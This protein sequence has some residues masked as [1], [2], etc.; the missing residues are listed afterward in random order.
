MA[1]SSRRRNYMLVS[2]RRDQFI[3]YIKGLLHHS[4]VLDALRE[5]GTN[6]WKHVEELIE[7]HRMCNDGSSRLA[8]AVPTI[9]QF[10]TPLPLA[11]T[12][13]AFD[14]RHC[15]SKR[16]FVQ[17]SF[18]EIR[19][20]LN[21]AQV[22]A[23]EMKTSEGSNRSSLEFVS[24]DGDCTLYSD[25]KNFNDPVLAHQILRLL[26]AGV[27]VA[28]V[29]AA[30]YGYDAA[31]YERRLD[32]LLRVLGVADASPQTLRRFFVVGGES[33]YL[34]QLDKRPGSHHNGTVSLVPRS[35]VWD[36]LAIVH[37]PDSDVETLLDVAEASIRQAI[38]DFNLDGARVIRKPRA[39]GLVP[40]TAR[41][42]Q[43]DETVLRVQNALR[44][45]PTNIPYCAF[46]GGNDVWV[47]VGNK[48]VGVS[49]LQQLFDLKP[50]N[51]LHIG[52]QFLNTGND[53]AARGCAP[54]ILRFILD[55]VNPDAPPI[56]D[57][58]WMPP[59]PTRPPPVPGDLTE[60]SLA[61]GACSV[62]ALVLMGVMMFVEVVTFA[63]RSPIVTK[64]DVDLHS[65]TQLRI[66]F[67]LSFPH[68]HCDF[69]SIDVWDKIGRNQ[70]NLSR[71]I[72]KWQLDEDGTRRMY[73]GRNR[74][75]Y[76]I[77]HDL[78]HPPLHELHADGV[79]VETVG[80]S[81]WAH[82]SEENEFSFV[83]FYAP[84]CSFC[85][86]LHSTWE[87]LAEE[88]ERRELPVA[89][90]S[91]DCVANGD[92][93]H[94]MYVQAFPTL[95]F[96]HHGDQVN[97][98]EYRFD[99]TVESLLEFVN[100]KLDSEAVYKQYPEARIAH[101]QNWNADHPGCLVSGYV[102]VN[103]VPGNFHIQAHS[104]HHSLNTF[105]TNLSH[106]V[107]HLSFGV[108]LN[109][110]QKRRLDGLD[111]K[112]HLTNPIDSREY[113]HG[114]FHHAYHHY[115]HVVPT[116]YRI[117][118]FWREKFHTYQMVH[119]DHLAFYEY[120]EPPEARFAFDLSPM[121]V[122]VDRVQK[123]WY[124]F[125]TGLLAILGGTFAVARLLNDAFSL[126]SRG[127]S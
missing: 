39:I 122:V 77:E 95:R 15:V 50:P 72:E 28:L 98:G 126:V 91:V 14:S 120:W 83:N 74:R 80:A 57:N 16:V 48:K 3:E 19:W 42:E 79:H 92:F 123:K 73:Q 18:N 33:N 47:D 21:E 113:L 88:I 82:F 111:I 85:Q 81:D 90:A 35:D 23:F 30:G 96:Y 55:V 52:D 53:Y 124:D 70:L 119:A 86:H 118:T 69:A 109:D 51:C 6:S 1:F 60:A 37:F 49:G 64:I 89:V 110:W 46:N 9:G 61:G 105:R 116:K 108:P 29:T 94:D 75:D 8:Q 41:R 54:Q 26:E 43:L 36:E 114:D 4:F 40:T 66:N 22:R 101:K 44:D 2:H 104:R 24:F 27:R 59:S 62:V 5:T 32:G 78:H 84:W 12:W 13:Q 106:T 76:D 97:Q 63:S 100:K 58:P 125:I 117:G 93:C 65:G 25:G 115:I 87:A 11:A 38:F 67:N 127:S 99:R 20:I 10:F 34:L 112:Y 31:R 103:R 7:E 68:L 121:A 71:N 17:P 107:H 102:M 45:V 56:P